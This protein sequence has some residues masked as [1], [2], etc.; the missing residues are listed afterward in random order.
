M[1]NDWN[2]K[3]IWQAYKFAHLNLSSIATLPWEIQ[4]SFTAILLIC[5]SDYLRYFK[6]KRT[7]TVTV[8]LP[9][10]YEE[11]SPHYL[12]KCR[13][14]SSD[15]RHITIIQM[16]LLLMP[17]K[18]AGCDVWQLK[19]QASNVTAS[20]QSD[21]LLHGRTLPVFFATDQS[22]RPPRSTEIQQMS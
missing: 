8:N 2:P 11:M 13:A 5:T 12:A 10:T 18:R 6:V 21:H 22:R 20:V 3:K 9:T 16:L 15:W 17:P 14:C 7:V 4:K 19:C 1:W